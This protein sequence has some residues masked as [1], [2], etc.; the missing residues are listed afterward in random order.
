MTE[1]S[2]S[3]GDEDRAGDVAD[4]MIEKAIR[5]GHPVTRRFRDK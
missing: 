2:Y 4:M 5:F 3:D 1:E